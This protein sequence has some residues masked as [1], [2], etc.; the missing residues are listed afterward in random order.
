MAEGAVDYFLKVDGID[1]E[2]EDSKHS[3]EIECISWSWGVSNQGT[4]AQGG[5]GGA[6]K[7]VPGDFSFTMYNCKA[8]PPL[9]QA[10]AEGKHIPKATFTARKAGGGQQDF[11]M[12]TFTDILVSSYNTSGSAGSGDV[13]PL[14]SISL[15]AAK[16][17]QEYKA[18]KK[19]GSLGGSVK[20]GYD[21]KKNVKV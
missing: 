8:S 3:G 6:G 19:D 15:N 13:R 14:D 11:L 4:F 5:G 1:G 7:S 17:E 9:M 21:W 18:Q 20:K 10:C 12:V 16:V 2:S